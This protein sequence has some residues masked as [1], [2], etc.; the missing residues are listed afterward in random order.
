MAKKVKAA[1]IKVDKKDAANRVGKILSVLKKDY[2]QAKTALR[3][4]N[5]LELLIATILSAQC[6]D[7]RVNMVT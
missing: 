1:K 6:P 7:A 3:F 2:P 5:P 4:T